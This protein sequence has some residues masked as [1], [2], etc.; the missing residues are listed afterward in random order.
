[1]QFVENIE[2]LEYIYGIFGGYKNE[3]INKAVIEIAQIDDSLESSIYD[4]D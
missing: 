4:D 3:N 2:S 1:L